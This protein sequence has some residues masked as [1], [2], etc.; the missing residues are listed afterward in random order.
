MNFKLDTKA[1][2][3]KIEIRKELANQK[4]N[5]LL[6]LNNPLYFKRMIKNFVQNKKCKIGCL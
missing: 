6:S 3:N 4:E 5:N 2:T 1:E